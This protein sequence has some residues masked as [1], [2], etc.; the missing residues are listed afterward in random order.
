MDTVEPSGGKQ[1]IIG[2]NGVIRSNGKTVLG[3]DDCAGIASILEALRVVKE[4][5]IP[6]RPIEVLFT[7]AEEVFC[8]GTEQFDFSKIKAKEA[9]VLD[10][11]GPIGSAAYQAP[12]ILSF[13]VTVSGKASHA[14]F[15]PQKGIHAIKAAADAISTLP[16][17][18][19]DNDTTINVG[20]IKGGRATNIIPDSC[21]VHG[22]IR[23][24]SHEKA[25][26]QAEIVKKHFAVAANAVGATTEFE[27]RIGCEAYKTQID[28]PVVKRFERACEK[29]GLPVLLEQTFGGSDNNNLAKH[30]IA[31]IVIA[32]AMNQCHSCEEYTTVEELSHAAELTVSLMSATD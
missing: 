10:L 28:H 26:R 31:G 17:G 7:I 4:Q 22:E 13:T 12:T 8:K 14:G 18:Q 5:D 20:V 9:Y 30:S 15:E 2:E 16:M 29:E 11:A 19:I 23:S 3:A 32:T 25:L 1:A 6:H 24:F 27:T 21:V